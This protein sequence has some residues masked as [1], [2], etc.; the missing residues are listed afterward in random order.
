M[1]LQVVA[2]APQVPFDQAR[3]ARHIFNKSFDRLATRRRPQRGGSFGFFDR[4]V[5]LKSSEDKPAVPKDIVAA[6]ERRVGRAASVVDF[7]FALPHFFLYF[8]FLCITI[9]VS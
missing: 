1:L 7:S 4:A 8:L 6:E 3:A 9:K 5:Q 2:R